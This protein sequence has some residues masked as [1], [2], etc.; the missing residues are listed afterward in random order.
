[1]NKKQKG[2]IL[3]VTLILLIILFTMGMTI[4]GMKSTQAKS[5]LMM[6]HSAMTKYIAEAGMEDARVK[7]LKD[8]DFPPKAEIN[9]H[10]FS[11][12]E[13]LRYP[14]DSKSIGQYTVTID[15]SKNDPSDSTQH[16]QTITVISEG[17]MRDSNGNIIARHKISAIL[18]TSPAIRGGTADNPYIYRYIDRRDYGNL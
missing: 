12:S 4:L 3:V 1:M 16:D 10:L 13:E 15:T 5:S 7:L 9:D 11:Y 2:S 14:G 8:V 6:T 17:V 18:D